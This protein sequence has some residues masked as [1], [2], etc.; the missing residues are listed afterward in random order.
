MARKRLVTV[1]E[2]ILLHLHE[3]SRYGPEDTVPIEL[4]QAGISRALGVRRSHVSMSLDSAQKKECVEECLARVKNESRRR[5]CYFLTP[6]GKENTRILK[7][8]IKSENVRAKLPHNENFQGT[9]SQLQGRIEGLSLQRLALLSSDGEVKL[10]A[11]EKVTETIN[12]IPEIEIFVGRGNELALLNNFFNGNAKI[13]ML[14]GMPGIGKTSLAARAAAGNDVFWFEIT[15]W[16]SPRNL[17]NHLAGYLAE[18]GFMR[19]QRY[20][21]A[22]EVP[23]IA[24]IHDILLDV[25]FP[26]NLIFDDCQAAGNSMTGFLKMLVS[27]C[28]ESQYI[29]VGF[30]AREMPDIFDLKQKISSEKIIQITLEPLKDEEGKKLLELRGIAGPEAAK[31]I[32]LAGGHPLYLSLAGI[33]SQG[34]ENSLEDIL[35]RMIYQNLKPQENEMLHLLSIFR[36]PVGSDALVENSQDIDILETLEKKCLIFHTG[37]WNMHSLVREFY[38]TRQAPPERIEIHEQAAEFYNIYTASTEGKIEETY[39][40]FKARDLE[41]GILNLITRG[42]G[43]LKVGYVDEIMYLTGM[44]PHDWHNPEDAFQLNFL[45]ASALELIG[46]WDAASEYFGLCYE[47]AIELDDKIRK[48][49]VLRKE[50]AIL[51]R[52]G[53]LKDAKRIFK[54]ALDI[55]KTADSPE[56]VALI[57]G[58][59]GVVEWRMGKPDIARKSHETDL[60]ISI[61][62]K[63]KDGIA[64]SLNNL[65]ILDWEAGD[66]GAAL[67][68]Y[69]VALELAEKL[70]DKKLV[71]ILYSNIADV[72]RSKNEPAEAKRYY[73]RCLEL[74]EDLKFNWQVAEA[75][76]GLAQVSD[77]KEKHLQRALAIFQRLGAEEDVKSIKEM[78]E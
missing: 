26:L 42:H 69:S 25:E 64:R 3:F 70:S 44:V 32:E 57:H 34:Q 67:E 61:E 31:I 10:P 78:M 23:D 12:K 60:E 47:A 36:Q 76:R 46:N 43:W 66:N 17:A 58:S 5:K 16:S 72:H 37:G 39:H 1:E 65:G 7:E 6:A 59:L 48:A 49:S 11:P 71:A 50:G 29:K 38:Y 27:V 74:A 13:L 15:D 2:A 20:L 22:H 52:Q 33:E 28:G 63:D 35:A 9:L 21:E 55:L 73:E 8:R 45:T 19:M 75:Y 68:R 41:T 24:D 18:K 77:D 51:Y 62:G 56:L 53:E 14:S 54:T 40:L 30:L 4:A